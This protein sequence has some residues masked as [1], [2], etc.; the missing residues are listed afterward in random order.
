MLQTGTDA[1][2]VG[3]FHQFLALLNDASATVRT[4]AAKVLGGWAVYVGCAALDGF[5]KR[6]NGLE[7]REALAMA[8]ARCD[9]T[10][11][12]DDELS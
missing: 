3:L 5:L 4:T 2:M 11:N 8:K 6:E 10:L 7:A 1:P 9:P 12:A